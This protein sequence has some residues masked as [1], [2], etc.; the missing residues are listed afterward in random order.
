MG[1]SSKKDTL[2][3]IVQTPGSIVADRHTLGSIVADRQTLGSDCGRQ[4]DPGVGLWPTDRQTGKQTGRPAVW[5]A[6]S[7]GLLLTGWSGHK[8]RSTA[9]VNVKGCN[10][11][12]CVC[13]RDYIRDCNGD[14][15]VCLRVCIRE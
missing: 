4:T 6:P 1:V 5:F 3:S 7:S 15:C 13:L 10:G 9:A 11:D 2:G 12:D 8:D 14:D